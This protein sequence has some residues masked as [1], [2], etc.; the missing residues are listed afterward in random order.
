MVLARYQSTCTTYNILISEPNRSDRTR[1]LVQHWR[2]VL[3]DHATELLPAGGVTDP[4][5][6]VRLAPHLLTVRVEFSSPG[7][8]I[9]R[10]VWR[11]IVSDELSG[12]LDPSRSSLSCHWLVSDVNQGMVTHRTITVLL[13]ISAHLVL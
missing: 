13:T 2:V 1:A 3:R 5:S 4:G 8:C 12:I 6:G 11:A 7:A 10:Y 9:L